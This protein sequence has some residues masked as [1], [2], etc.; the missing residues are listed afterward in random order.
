MLTDLELLEISE[1]NLEWFQENSKE[2][3][4]QFTNKIIAIKDKRIIA[5]AENINEL[6][7]LLKEKNIDSS[8]VLIEP[9]F[10]KKEI[11]VL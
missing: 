10:S 4:E 8:E 2:I 1:E 7:K 9:I 11:I 3:Q 5:S 6:L